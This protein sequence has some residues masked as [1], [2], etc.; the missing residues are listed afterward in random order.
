MQVLLIEDD[1]DVILVKRGC[2]VR[3]ELTVPAEIFPCDLIITDFDPNGPMT[4]ADSIAHV[5]RLLR[6]EVP[7]IVMTGHDGTRVRQILN[8]TEIPVLSKPVRPGR[9]ALRA[10][11]LKANRSD[12]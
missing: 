8:D 6:Q 2:K 11:Q 1:I 9:A 7:A 4:G 12:I 5:R 3:P 10:Q